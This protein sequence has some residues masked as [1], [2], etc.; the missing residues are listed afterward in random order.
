PQPHPQLIKVAEV[1]QLWI[2]PVKSCRGA[3]LTLAEC[4][5]LGLGSGPLKDRHWIIVDEACH[6]I[7]GRVQPSLVLVSVSKKNDD[8]C[9]NATG[10][11]ELRIPFELP[12][13]NPVKM[14]RVF[15]TDI[16]GR[17][18]GDKA[19]DWITTYLKNT[20]PFRLMSYEPTMKPRRS[21]NNA[22][23]FR[24]S[25]QIAYSDLSACMLLSEAS[26]EDL[27]TRLEKKV[28]VENFRPVIV[29]KDCEPY[30]E[31]TWTAIQIGNVKFSRVMGCT[32]CIF[33]TVDPDTGIISRKEPLQTLKS[34]RQCDPS[35][36][37]IY[38]SDALFGV[39]FRI[40]ETGVI[41]VGD[42][43]YKIC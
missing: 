36:K 17:D 16:E 5:Q 38:K 4:S 43:V 21:K 37:H 30:K 23:V 6:M 26:V 8:L 28:K 13:S 12:K 40:D 33:T 22:P 42:P 39:H 34:Y 10:M 2:Y 35:E 25:D 27:N 19:A 15:Q 9:L 24:D 7:T 31:E 18:C 14:L 20:Q 1:S 32:R 29:V 41:Q 11:Q 3:A